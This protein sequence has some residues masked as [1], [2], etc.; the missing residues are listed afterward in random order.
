MSIIAKVTLKF[1]PNEI[2]NAM[3]KSSEMSAEV[4]RVINM[5]NKRISRIKE[6]NTVISPAL[7]ALQKQ[8]ID[9]FAL[10][11]QTWEQQKETY[12]RAIE[13]L[14]QE[15]SSLGG[16]RRFTKEF[17]EKSG[18]HSEG[19]SP[20]Q[21]EKYREY[22]S[23]IIDEYGSD[24]MNNDRLMYNAV[25]QYFYDMKVEQAQNAI[26]RGTMEDIARDDKQMR[27]NAKEI[28]KAMETII[29]IDEK[30][31]QDKDKEFSKDMEIIIE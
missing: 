13:Y 15:S 5:A 23:S 17:L 3:K 14:N 22:A 9:K 6:D 11:G 26:E 28:S 20:E 4:R 31:M 19:G 25:A 7:K 24:V 2:L 8:G 16:A 18:L 1:D 10:R 27:D 12:F 29:E 30:Q 21:E